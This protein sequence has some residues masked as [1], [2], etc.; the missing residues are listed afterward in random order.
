MEI[1]DKFVKEVTAHFRYLTGEFGFSKPVLSRGEYSDT[2]TYENPRMG[3]TVTIHNAYHPVD[4]GFEFNVYNLELG[5]EI[6]GDHLK[7]HKMLRFVL[8]EN[9][10]PGQSYIR[11]VAEEIYR[12]YAA[13]LK[14]ECW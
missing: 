4:Y 7:N 2:F 3:R 5:K 11:G 9:Q 13:L 12:E 8:K 1:S 14:G 10:D 6:S